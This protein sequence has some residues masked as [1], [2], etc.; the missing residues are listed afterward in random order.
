MNK[1]DKKIRLQNL[2]EWVDKVESTYVEYVKKIYPKYRIPF[3]YY[4]ELICKIL[5]RNMSKRVFV[6]DTGCGWKNREVGKYL[7]D[8]ITAIGIDVDRDALKDNITYQNLV[9]CDLEYIPFKDGI[10]DL[11]TNICVLEHIEHPYKVFSEYKRIAKNKGRLVFIFPNLLNPL[12]LLGK[13]TPT[14]LHKK[15]MKKFLNRDE[16]DIFTTFFR[17]NTESSFEKLAKKFGFKRRR[18]IKCG[19]FTMCIFNRFLLRCWIIFDKLTNIGF[20][21]TF[22]MLIVIDYEKTD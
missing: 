18:I 16:E 3:H 2:N 6:L 19:D 17:C 7:N 4:D 1:I 15:F 11:V 21:N 8:N 13:M 20:L 22:K 9:L 5:N 12:M 10:F 14:M